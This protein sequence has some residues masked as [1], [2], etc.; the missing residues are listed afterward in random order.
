MCNKEQKPE[1]KGILEKKTNLEALG[2]RE[3]L[4][5]NNSEVRKFV[6]YPLLLMNPEDIYYN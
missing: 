4:R 6:M 2:R 5:D 1:S 3:G